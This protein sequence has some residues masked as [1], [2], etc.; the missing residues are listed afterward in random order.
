MRCTFFFLDRM[1]FKHT[2]AHPCKRSREKVCC[3]K[4]ITNISNR[5][6][7][8]F[9]QYQPVFSRY[10]RN[11]QQYQ[12]IK[13]TCT[14]IFVVYQMH[15]RWT[16][17]YVIRSHIHTP[18]TCRSAA[19]MIYQRLLFKVNRFIVHKCPYTFNIHINNKSEDRNFHHK[20]GIHF[21]SHI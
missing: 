3:R 21:Y 18:I 10:V 12:S 1:Y 5:I 9:E 14:S 19:H 11:N 4:A 20:N 7:T 17:S 2:R 6:E 16:Q 8:F 15:S 13:S